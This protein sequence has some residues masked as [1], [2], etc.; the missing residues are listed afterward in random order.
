MK[1]SIKKLRKKINKQRQILKP[2]FT[3]D[4]NGFETDKADFDIHSYS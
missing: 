2:N 4:K 3:Q 1:K